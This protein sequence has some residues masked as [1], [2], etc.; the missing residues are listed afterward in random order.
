MSNHP[1]T[2]TTSAS[3]H[4]QGISDYIG[5]KQ[6]P[7][8]ILMNEKAAAALLGWSVKTL[9]ARRFKSQPPRYLK[10]GGRS[11]RYRLSDLEEFVS[12][13]VVEPLA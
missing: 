4:V 2:L 10:V 8:D 11:V 12:A 5:S 7:R 6:A 9:Q 3:N 13:S 1:I